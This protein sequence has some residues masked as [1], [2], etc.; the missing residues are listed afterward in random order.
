[1]WLENATVFSAFGFA[2]LMNTSDETARMLKESTG[3]SGSEYSDFVDRSGVTDLIR[4]C[5]NY[6]LVVIGIEGFVRDSRSD[7]MIPQ[8]DLIAHIQFGS[9]DNWEDAKAFCFEAATSFVEQ[10]PSDPKLYVILH[11]LDQTEWSKRCGHRH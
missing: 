9:K 10:L 8:L 11:V 1:M 4:S 3:Q 2:Q 5:T 6:D 7:A